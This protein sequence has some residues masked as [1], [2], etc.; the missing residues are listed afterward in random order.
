MHLLLS[1]FSITLAL[2]LTLTSCHFLAIVPNHNL[3]HSSKNK[4]RDYRFNYDIAYQPQDLTKS[5]PTPKADAK[6]RISDSASIFRWNNAGTPKPTDSVEKGNPELA[7]KGNRLVVDTFY[8][9]IIVDN[10]E[11]ISIDTVVI[12]NTKLFNAILSWLGTRYRFGGTTRDNVDCSALTRALIVST[13]NK[14]IPRT[15]AEQFRISQQISYQDLQE[16]DLVFFATHR[17]KRVSHVG[18][19]LGNDYFIHS[20]TSSGV[21]LSSL[22]TPYWKTHL[23]GCGRYSFQ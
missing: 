17:K 22:T 13:F 14:S 3:A 1:R 23:L 6:L 11:I 20:G 16:G 10:K 5:T 21:T 4:T 2:I 15:S 8:Q 19:Y 7:I 18:I 12:S 9:R